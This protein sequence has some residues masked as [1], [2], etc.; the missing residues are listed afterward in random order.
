V[1]D[2]SVLKLLFFSRTKQIPLFGYYTERICTYSNR[3]QPA[4]QMLFSERPSIY[5]CVVHDDLGRNNRTTRY[6]SFSAVSLS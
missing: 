5:A 1:S 2:F 3:L 4:L 6:F